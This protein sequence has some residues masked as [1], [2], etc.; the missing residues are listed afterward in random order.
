MLALLSLGRLAECK[1]FE[2]ADV[3]PGNLRGFVVSNDYQL[4]CCRDVAVSLRQKG[5]ADLSSVIDRAI[6][7]L[8]H[9]WQVAEALFR[10]RLLGETFVDRN[11]F[12]AKFHKP[13]AYL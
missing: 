11:V 12:L 7:A 9:L 3:R 4:S 2:Q 8:R 10:S 1:A 5:R 13:V 6:G